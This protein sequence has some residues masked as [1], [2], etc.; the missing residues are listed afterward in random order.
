MPDFSTLIPETHRS[1]SLGYVETLIQTQREELSTGL[2]RLRYPS[3]E[4]LFFSFLEGIQQ[5]LYRAVENRV[6]VIPRHTWSDALKGTS[7]SAGFLS[8]PVEAMR[9]VRIAHEAP[10][11]HVEEAKLTAEELTVHAETWAA[12]QEPRIV[13]LEAQGIKKYYLIAGCSTPIIEELSFGEQGAHFNIGDASFSRALPNQNYQI[14]QYVSSRD[15]ELWREYE[16]RLAFSPLMRMLFSR[17]SELAGRV[18]TERLCAQLFTWTRENG[19]NMAVTSNGI[20]NHHYF[21]S[22]DSAVGVYAELLRRFR[23]EASQAIGLRMA[24]GLSREI[25]VKLDPYRRELLTQYIYS[26]DGVGSIAGVVWR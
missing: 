26:Q 13:Y 19:W 17:F 9:F 15:H 10:I 2:M 12:G 20:V 18:L 21:D 25:L 4:N 14:T 23:Q 7:L 3:G 1:I 6:E 24:D 11:V 5:K 16:L 8:L 22:L